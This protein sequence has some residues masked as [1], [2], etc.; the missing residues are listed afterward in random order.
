MKKLNSI[1]T[2][3][4]LMLLAGVSA[5]CSN[6]A[7]AIIKTESKT[8]EIDFDSIVSN[9]SETNRITFASTDLNGRIV[10]DKIFADNKIT[11]LNIWATFCSPCIREM[12]EL[13]KLCE[14]NKGKGVHVIGVPFDI[15]DSYGNILEE[16]K[17]D[18]ETIINW[19]KADYIN[20]IPNEAMMNSF[21]RNIR[22]V[23]TTIFVDSEGNQIGDI[24]EGAKCQSEWQEII[25]NLL[26]NKSKIGEC[27]FTDSN[28]RRGGHK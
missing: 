27:L 3:I 16:K 1:S 23:P 6:N 8:M 15:I 24:Y 20:I 22:A 9:K 4:F 26:E 5:A 19:A 17:N 10:T 11:M 13:A 21:L 7:D 25:D 2:I 18:A 14:E 28:I 12:P